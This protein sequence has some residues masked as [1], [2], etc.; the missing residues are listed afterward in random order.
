MEKKKEKPKSLLSEAARFLADPVSAIAGG[1]IGSFKKG[2]N[3]VYWLIEQGGLG[4][5]EQSLDK[6][7]YELLLLQTYRQASRTFKRTKEELK[8]QLTLAANGRKFGTSHLALGLFEGLPETAIEKFY[9]QKN[10]S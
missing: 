8:L 3:L 1:L 9:A 6:C 4:Q 10:I 7:D 5:L 2:V